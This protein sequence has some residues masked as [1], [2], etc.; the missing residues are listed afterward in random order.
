MILLGIHAQ[1][2][3][4]LHSASGDLTPKKGRRI[5]ASNEEIESWVSGMLRTNNIRIL[6]NSWGPSRPPN[7]QAFLELVG[8]EILKWGRETWMEIWRLEM[9]QQGDPIRLWD[10]RH[11]QPEEEEDTG[12]QDMEDHELAPR[13]KGKA[14]HAAARMILR[15]WR[16]GLD[17]ARQAEYDNLSA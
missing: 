11:P 16:E 7:H 13:L 1:M 2:G 5:M 9:L 12:I 15:R 8:R 4:R 10:S 17:A 3:L 14:T 6:L